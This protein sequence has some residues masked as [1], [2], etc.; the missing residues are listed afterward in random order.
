MKVLVTGA[1][2]FIGKYVCESLDEQG[3]EYVRGTRADFDL[4]SID[5]MVNV[6]NSSG[7]THIIHLAARANTMD[8]ADLFEANIEGLYKLLFAIKKSDVKHIT[9]ASGNNVYGENHLLAIDE[10]VLPSP[11]NGNTYALS[12]Y[13]GEL[14]IQDFLRGSGTDYALIRIA[15]V[16]GPNQKFG[17][18]IKAIVNSVKDSASIKLYGEGKR[19][20]DYIFVKD[21]AD[22]LVFSCVNELCGVYNL[23][24]GVGTD[25]KTLVDIAV[26][27]SEG[28]CGVE[29]VEINNEDDSKIVLNP[30]KLRQVGFETKYTILEGLRICVEG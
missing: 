27:L 8:K 24:T 15:D 26:Q 20:R 16:Y 18:L 22:G 3:V 5:S 4:N 17:N 13:V 10:N 9:F 30:D 23:S 12:K 1:N 19:T 29:K 14:L 7:I 25:V 28:K 11:A 21:V 6:L 2:G